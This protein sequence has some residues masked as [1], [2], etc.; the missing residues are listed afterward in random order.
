MSPRTVTIVTL[1]KHLA[2]SYYGVFDRTAIPILKK[3]IGNDL[4]FKIFTNLISFYHVI[5]HR[6]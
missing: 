3:H 2:L 6:V 5:K 4:N 1:D